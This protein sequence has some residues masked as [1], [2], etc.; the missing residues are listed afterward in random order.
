MD[1][2]LPPEL[3]AK[4]AAVREFVQDRLIPLEADPASYDEHENIAPALLRVLRG[5]AKAAGLWALQSK[6]ERG[7]GELPFIGMAACYEEMNRS[8]FG[9]RK[10]VV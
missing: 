4:R 6:R 1:F 5:E 10:S 3:D 7:G 8:I 2:S 9:D